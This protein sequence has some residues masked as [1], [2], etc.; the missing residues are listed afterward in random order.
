[1]AKIV[2][3]TSDLKKLPEEVRTVLKEYIFGERVDEVQATSSENFVDV[4]NDSFESKK[5]TVFF[6]VDTISLEASIAFLSGLDPLSSIPCIEYLI[7]HEFASKET[8]ANTAGKN[9]SKGING[10]VGSINRRFKS[11]FSHDDANQNLI[12]Y[13]KRDKT[14]A[15]DESFHPALRFGIWAVK[16]DVDWEAC[17]E[18]NWHADYEPEEVPTWV[19]GEF[20]TKLKKN[21]MPDKL[22]LNVSSIKGFIAKTKLGDSISQGGIEGVGDHTYGVTRQVLSNQPESNFLFISSELDENFWYCD[23]YMRISSNEI[24]QDPFFLAF[25]KDNADFKQLGQL[26]SF[27]RENKFSDRDEAANYASTTVDMEAD[28]GKFGFFSYGDA[29]GGIGG[30]IGVF[31]WFANEKE[32]L[33]QIEQVLPF[34]PPGPSSIS[35]ELVA[36][37]VQKIIEKRLNSAGEDE[38]EMQEFISDLNK[39]L[40]RF[41]QI[42]WMGQFEDLISA[43]VQTDFEKGVRETFFDNLGKDAYE[44]PINREHMDVFKD[45]LNTFGF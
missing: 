43:E 12:Y 10:L 19:E 7:S 33:D 23:D 4:L 5:S 6:P 3:T 40:E 24:P 11:L 44:G 45:T 42:E 2:L 25:F 39:A 15:I 30:G 18:I 16:Q 34:D 22:E 26:A 8:L 17:K 21:K 32:A 35:P 36:S 31:Q 13:R 29:P 9:D 38:Y 20:E 37:E 28:F 1:M 14:Y 41:S 27:Y